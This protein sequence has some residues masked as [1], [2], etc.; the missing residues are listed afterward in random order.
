MSFSCPICA[1][2]FSDR[3]ALNDHLNINDQCHSDAN[4]IDESLKNDKLWNEDFTSE[5]LAEVDRVMSK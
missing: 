2:D 5:E 3:D 4:E 1:F